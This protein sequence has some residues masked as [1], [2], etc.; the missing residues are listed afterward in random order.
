MSA[1]D[2]ERIREAQD[3]SF[4]LPLL[5]IVLNA[6]APSPEWSEA[7]RTLAHVEDHRVV[8]PLT[9]Y[10]MNRSAGVFAPRPW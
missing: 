8:V 10:I 3:R 6:P 4:T 7:A 9:R 2:H 5:D 1:L